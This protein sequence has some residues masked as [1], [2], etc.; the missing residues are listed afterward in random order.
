MNGVN[1]QMYVRLPLAASTALRALS[2][3]IAQM[4]DH[5]EPYKDLEFAFHLPMNAEIDDRPERWECGF[6]IS[7]LREERFFPCFD[8]MLSLTPVGEDQ[9]ELWLQGHYTPPGGR[10]GRLLDDTVLH[11]IAQKSLGELL[12]GIARGV[13]RAAAAPLRPPEES[14]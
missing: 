8:G 2:T 12:D 5:A 11:G 13:T 1:V 9:S 7:T 6:K 10:V 3:V 4:R 14:R